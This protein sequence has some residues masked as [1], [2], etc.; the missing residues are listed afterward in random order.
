MAVEVFANDGQ[1]TVT[2]GGTTAPSAGTTETW[3]LSG[4]TL[5]AVSSSASPP[6]QCYVCDPAAESEK[7]LIVN[8]SGTTAT[9]TRG[10]DGTTPVAHSSGFTVQ[11]VITRATMQAL[12]A[13]GGGHSFKLQGWLAALAGR[14]AAR[15]NVVILGDSITAG[16]GATAFANCYAQLLP[17][18]LNARFPTTGL[19]AHGRGFLP[20]VL[21]P[22]NP[23]TFSPPYIALSGAGAAN[24]HLGTDSGGAALF[25]FGPNLE[26]YDLSANGGTTLT[27][28]LTGDSADILWAGS[29]GNGTFS[30]KVDAGTAT[31]VSTNVAFNVAAS[32]HISL[33]SAGAH[34]LTLTNVSGGPTFITGVVEYAGDFA[35]GIQVH[36]C[37]FSGSTT[38]FWTGP[39]GNSDGAA[40]LP[41]LSPSLI[42]I[43]LG[44]NDNASGISAAT[45]AANITSM[46]SDIRAALS[47]APPILLL[48][49]YN[50]ASD[51]PTTPA[52]WAAYVQ[53]MYGIAAADSAVDI[54]DLTLRMPSTGAANT[55]SLYAG[56][57]IHPVNRG[58]QMIADALCQY[59]SPV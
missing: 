11:Q 6:T 26:T 17:V 53:A 3:T 20:P 28:S 29:T 37:G 5:A 38:G 32:T 22:S 52:Q 33:G 45:S 57:G 59:L 19:A 18:L 25:G 2:S 30:W 54:L 14:A 48:A 47:P 13:L 4:S 23:T 46:I 49:M 51:G 35:R 56:D 16:Q 31:N 21:P 8:I 42:I 39:G 55:W 24:F 9:V 1:A 12:Q 43:A 50:A 15:A 27:Y 40:S 10:A 36:D 58:H 41:A 44:V 34:T 7:I